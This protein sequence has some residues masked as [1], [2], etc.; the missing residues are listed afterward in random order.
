MWMH[1]A[2]GDHAVSVEGSVSS[3]KLSA[4]GKR[5]YYLLRKGNSSDVTELW[6]RDLASGKSDPVLTGL[7]IVDYDILEDQAQVAFS[8]RSGGTSQISVAALDRSSP[9]R[10][11]TKDGDSVSFGG[12]AALLFRQL[13]DKANFL[14]RI[15]TDGSGLERISPIANKDTVSP[16]R[17]WAVV[18]G[19]VDP[20]VPP[21]TYAVSLRDHGRRHI[22]AGL[23]YVGWSRD[24]KFLYVTTFPRFT[25]TGRTIMVPMPR[26]FA[27]V[28]V[29]A[30][31][32]DRASDE[33]LAGLRVIRR[34]AIS[35]GPDP[36]TYTFT[37]AA[38]QGNLF[39]IPLH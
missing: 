16:D 6:S 19:A 28:Q 31:G 11:V 38:F 12:N 26:G 35:P 39:R 1:D 2:S 23:C 17:E 33:E 14:A 32:F 29:P 5:L 20:S 7:R 21:G 15:Q 22:C 37:T 34:G 4:D 36:D 30:V 8:V 13:G 3:P 27:Q 25:S 10:L 9:P 18:A 24:G